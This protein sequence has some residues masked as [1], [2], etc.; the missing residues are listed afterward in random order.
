MKSFYNTIF[1]LLY[2]VIIPGVLYSI[3]TYF[4]SLIYVKYEKDNIAA[5]FIRKRIIITQIK[6]LVNK[7][8]FKL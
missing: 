3:N 7:S 2:K 1:S 8:W 6:M 5:F 4:S